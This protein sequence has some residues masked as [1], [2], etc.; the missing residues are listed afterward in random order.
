MAGVSE[1]S[2]VSRKDQQVMEDMLMESIQTLA[3]RFE[4]EFPIQFQG[5]SLATRPDG[6]APTSSREGYLPRQVHP[7]GYDLD[8]IVRARVSIE[9]PRVTRTASFFM[10]RKET[11]P[12]GRTIEERFGACVEHRSELLTAR[13][14]VTALA[15][16]SI[17]DRFFGNNR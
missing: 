12:D 10:E 11:F 7:D 5:T 17:L 4:R 1:T 9:I 15:G 14:D 13:G 3:A 2:R 8:E 16:P 6:H